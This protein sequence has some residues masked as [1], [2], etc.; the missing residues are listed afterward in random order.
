MKRAAVLRQSL[1]AL[2]LIA[3]LSGCAISLE[4]VRAPATASTPAN[5]AN[6]PYIPRNPLGR[7]CRP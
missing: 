6:C 3:P 7:S 5:L 2:A 4:P 1:L